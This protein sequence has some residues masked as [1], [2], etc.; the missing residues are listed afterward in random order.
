ME[1]RITVRTRR[2]GDIARIEVSDTGPGVPSE[3]RDR[4]FEPFFTTR[5]RTGGTGL[6]LWLARGIVEEEGGTLTFHNEAGSGACFIVDLPAVT[7]DAAEGRTR[8][9][10]RIRL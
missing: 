4:I 9:S 5:E 8:E 10:V 6:G 1:N 3:I 7:P 2:V